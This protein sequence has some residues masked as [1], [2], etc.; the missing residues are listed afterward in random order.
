[1]EELILSLVQKY[2]LVSSILVVIGVLRAIFK[3]LTTLLQKYVKA[4][5]SES[6]NKLLQKVLDSK[7]YDA[8][9]WFLDYT[10]S[11]KLPKKEKK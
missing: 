2:P 4:T 3:P 6:D 9:Q 10:A 11:I 7:V 8:I 1:M 5:P